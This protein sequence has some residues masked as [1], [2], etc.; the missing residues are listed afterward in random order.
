MMSKVRS[1]NRIDGYSGGE[2][3]YITGM[4]TMVQTVRLHNII[5]GYD[6]DS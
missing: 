5:D 1:H 3:D 6:E 4:M 2:L